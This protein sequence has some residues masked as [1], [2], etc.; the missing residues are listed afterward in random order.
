MTL[1]TITTYTD[2]MKIFERVN[3]I[4]SHNEGGMK[5]SPNNYFPVKIGAIEPQQRSNRLSPPSGIKVISQDFG[6]ITYEY[7][8]EIWK[9][10]LS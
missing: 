2:F 5:V 7:D 4:P 1:K 3:K 10:N 9:C 6:K 8:T